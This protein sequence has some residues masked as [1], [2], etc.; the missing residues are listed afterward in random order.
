MILILKNLIIIAFILLKMSTM[1]MS[2]FSQVTCKKGILLVAFGST[3]SEARQAQEKFG[4]NVKAEFPGIEVR[5]AYT[6]AIVR[7]KLK[8]QGIQIDSPAG[9]LAKFSGDGFSHIAVQ[10]L[11]IIP[12]LEYEDLSA[13]VNAFRGIPKGFQTI[14]LGAPL[15]YMSSDIKKVVNIVDSLLPAGFK[16]GDA[17]VFMG[18]GTDHPSDNF[19]AAMQYHLWEK[20]SLFF[21]A[22]VEGLPDLSSLIPKLSAQKVKTVWITPFMSIAGDHAHNDMAGTSPDSWKSQ[23]QRAGFNVKI[24]MKGLIEFECVTDLWINHL[25]TIVDELDR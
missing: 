24:I 8:K 12:G 1:S 5:W 13:T 22:T 9:A 15:L 17:L 2:L 16:K 20:S 6:S 7:N 18:H 25:K 23:L 19:Y 11:H 3:Y 14:L 21:M 4:E 10:S